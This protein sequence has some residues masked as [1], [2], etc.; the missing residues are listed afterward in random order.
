MPDLI[1]AGFDGEI[2]C[3]HATKALL[4]PML[5]DALSFTGRSREPVIGERA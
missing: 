2:I 4:I 1:E 5:R 3:T